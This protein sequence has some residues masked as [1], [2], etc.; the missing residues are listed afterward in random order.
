M[1]EFSLVGFVIFDQ[2]EVFFVNGDYIKVSC[3]EFIEL[4]IIIDMS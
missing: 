3:G 4:E 2:V 1:Y